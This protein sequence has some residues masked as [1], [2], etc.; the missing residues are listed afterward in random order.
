MTDRI[1]RPVHCGW[2]VK[3]KSKTLFFGRE[4]DSYIKAWKEDGMEVKKI[5]H[6]PEYLS[7]ANSVAII[8]RL[9]RQLLDISPTDPVAVSV[10]RNIAKRNS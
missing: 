5:Y 3:L 7:G 2:S 6:V 4:A 8:G 9:M 1:P 10:L